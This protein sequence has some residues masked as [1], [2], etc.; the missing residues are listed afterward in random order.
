M[1]SNT[2]LVLAVIAGVVA[3]ALFMRRG[4]GDER[5]TLADAPGG[6]ADAADDGGGAG[7]PGAEDDAPLVVESDGH[8]WLPAL[9]GLRRLWLGDEE[10]DPALIAAGYVDRDAFD[11]LRAEARRRGGGGLTGEPFHPGDFSAARIVRG[12]PGVDPWRLETLGPDGEYVH[13][14]FETEDAARAALELL[15]RHRI[16]RRPLDEDG[17]PVPAA[18]GDFEEAR[19]RAEDTERALAIEDDA[20]EDQ[21]R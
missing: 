20:D 7:E 2:L 16:V 10:A 11:R 19:R 5:V 18:R 21:R 12:T 6:D 8:V 9:S 13:F 14:G 17:E 4:S 3:I 1:S 15:E